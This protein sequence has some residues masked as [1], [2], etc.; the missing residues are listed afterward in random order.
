MRPALALLLLLAGCSAYQVRE[1]RQDILGM[2]APD[3]LA[4]AGVPYKVQELSANEL[5]IQYDPSLRCIGTT[6][7]TR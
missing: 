7:I 5:M 3:L 1:A 2:T 4:C 6:M